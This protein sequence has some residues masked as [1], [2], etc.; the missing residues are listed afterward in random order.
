VLF[1]PRIVS[2][3]LAGVADLGQRLFLGFVGGIGQHHRR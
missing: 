2:G 1:Q 3:Q